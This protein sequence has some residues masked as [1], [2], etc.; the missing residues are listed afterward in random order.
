MNQNSEV[1]CRE[2][3]SLSKTERQNLRNF[4]TQRHAVCRCAQSLRKL[5]I[6]QFRRG[7]VLAFKDFGHIFYSAQKFFQGKEGVQKWYFVPA[8]LIFWKTSRKTLTIQGFIQ[9]V[10]TCLIEAPMRRERKQRIQKKLF[11]PFYTR[12]LQ[13]TTQKVGQ[14]LLECSKNTSKCCKSTEKLY[15]D[16]D[17]GCFCWTYIAILE[18][19]SIKEHRKQWRKIHSQIGSI[20]HYPWL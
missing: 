5:W 18:K 11:Q 20:C 10:K 13:K 17:K 9:F 19:I 7:N 8:S 15:I 12:I 6:Y 1:V 16:L 14:N 4:C 2:A 3:G